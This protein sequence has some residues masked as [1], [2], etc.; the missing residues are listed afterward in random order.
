MRDDLDA[1]PVTVLLAS[2][3][4]APVTVLDGNAA[5][6]MAIVDRTS[7]SALGEEWDAAGV[8]LLLDPVQLDGT[9]GVYVGKAPS[10]LRARLRQH[11]LKKE[12]WARALLVVRD[13]TYG[14]DSAQ[15]GWLEGRLYDLLD[16]AT[17][18]SLSNGNRP[19]DETV[20]P[21]DR[22]ALEA[23][24]EPIAAMLRLLGCSPDTFDD[25]TASAEA[26]APSGAE[27]RRNPR[28]YDVSLADLLAAG[29]LS[30]GERLTSTQRSAPAVSTLQPDGTLE[31][32]GRS[33]P[34]PSSAGAA[35]RGGKSTNGWTLWAVERDE[36]SVPL[37]TIRARYLRASV[38]D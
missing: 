16:G 2:E 19:Q 24:V 20:R 26:P 7:L 29:Y 27:G 10:G 1:M 5:L 30:A 3:P 35:V 21:Y 4:A 34:S 38:S 25:G 32:D 33:Y 13:T 14:W 37:A 18:A 6:R 17:L 31:Y 36:S 8:Y 9:F 15:V 11:R 23:A 12:H 22:V 28:S